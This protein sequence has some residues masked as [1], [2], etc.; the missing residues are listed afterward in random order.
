MLQGSA[1]AL[2]FLI[3]VARVGVPDVADDGGI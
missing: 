2:P 1:S 3:P